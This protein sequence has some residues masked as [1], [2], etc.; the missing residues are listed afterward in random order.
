M[1]ALWRRGGFTIDYK[2]E[3]IFTGT[4]VTPTDVLEGVREVKGNLEISVN[5]ST[6]MMSYVTNGSCL[7]IEIGFMNAPMSSCYTFY[8]SVIRMNSVTVPGTD[9]QRQRIEWTSK[10][11]TR[12]SL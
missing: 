10:Y 1:T 11:V 5:E 8:S 3:Q 12:S 6:K 4:G 9:V 7:N 2:T